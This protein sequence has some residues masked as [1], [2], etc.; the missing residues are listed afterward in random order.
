MT[1]ADDDGKVVVLRRLYQ[2][3]DAANGWREVFASMSMTGA[4]D[5]GGRELLKADQMDS[6]LELEVWDC[7]HPNHPKVI[8]HFIHR[9]NTL[10]TLD[11]LGSDPS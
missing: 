3:R 1:C 7:R 10:G 6:H 5:M 11:V 9:V 4:L 2:V 8:A